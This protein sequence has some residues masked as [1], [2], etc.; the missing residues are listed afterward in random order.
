MLPCTNSLNRLINTQINTVNDS[1]III[2]RAFRKGQQHILNL[3]LLSRL[4][5]GTLS[6]FSKNFLGTRLFLVAK[7]AQIIDDTE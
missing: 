7:N 6:I 4:A 5:S 1:K 3:G 2:F